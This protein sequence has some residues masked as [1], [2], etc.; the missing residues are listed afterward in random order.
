MKRLWMLVGVLAL[1]VRANAQ[2]VNPQG[3]FANAVNVNKPSLWLNFNDSTTAFKD[4]VSGASF[5]PT[6]TTGTILAPSGSLSA[7]Y[8]VV[9]GTVLPAMTVNQISVQF[10]TAP[11]AGPYTFVVV[12]GTAPSLTIASSF[13]L[14]VAATTA[15]Q[16]FTAPVNF[17]AFPVTAGE[18]F[19]YWASSST[20][21]VAYSA[22]GSGFYYAAAAS[23]LPLG[24]QTYGSSLTQNMSLA[25]G[26]SVPMGAGTAGQAGFDNTNNTNNSAG[27]AYN[28]FN[29]APSSAMSAIDWGSAWTMLLHVDR[30]NWDRTGT[31]VLASKGDMGSSLNSYWE[32][33]L[34]PSAT[35]ATASQ[36]CFLRNGYGQSQ[37]Q[38]TVCSGQYLDA[39]PNGFN[40][41]I[42][43]EDAGT[44]APSALSLY[45]NGTVLAT[46][47]GS[48]SYANGFGNVALGVSGGTGYASTTAFTSTGG[49]AN[50]I[51]TG[52]MY[53]TSGVPTSIT[54]PG[55][56][57]NQGCVSNATIVLTTPTGTGAVITATAK[58]MTMNSSTAPLMVPG[59]VSSGTTYGVGGT[60]AAQNPVYVDEFAL[61]PSAL[62]FGAIS[63]IFYETKF[64]QGLLYPGITA[65]PPL[66]ILGN[67]GCGPDYSG[68]Q[69]TAMVIG[70]HRAGLI[71]LIGVVD[72]D[73]AAN[74]LNSVA[75]YRQ[76]LDEAGLNDV[77]VSVGPN[78]T[79]TNTGGC[80]VANLTAYNASTPQNASA[81]G[82]SV[83][84]Y[85]TLFAKYPSTPIYVLMTQSANGYNAFQLSAADSLSPLTGLQLQAQNVAN[86]GW[87]NAFNGNN[88]ITPA[89][90]T[91]VLNNSGSMPVYF[92]G[93]TPAPGGPGIEAS[94]R[95]GDPLRLAA[96]ALNQDTIS[97]WT[98]LNLSQVLSPYFF[99][100]VLITF[101]GGTGYA[102]QTGY[103]STGG[104]TYCH[105]TG[106]MTASGGVPNGIETAWGAALPASAVY[107]GL[108][109]GCTSVPT[110]VLTAPTGSGV[111]LT[112]TTTILSA[113][114]GGAGV[115][116]YTVYPSQWGQ[117]SNSTTDNA[118][119]FTW[120]QNSLM[121]PPTNGAPRAF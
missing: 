103:T 55:T 91:S 29:V 63:N 70:A 80:P 26:G 86:G 16:T 104:G 56:S 12:S 5:G 99:G 69:T 18:R 64:Y 27:F 78:S 90:L 37:S 1:T 96:I 54:T 3:T 40:Y 21:T 47:G 98:N 44:G 118:P 112:A 48:N 62:S 22:S 43:I 25:V 93:S 11:T 42:V 35:F 19:G 83:T 59:Y 36:I 23:S 51:V 34:H 67:Q 89:A 30:L 111:A 28:Q 17:T 33:Y 105:V 94:R 71:R 77:P 108:G 4:S 121:D 9:Q 116:Q 45:V 46:S 58:A 14:T 100:G 107:N 61:F 119:V 95:V 85:R 41:D 76:M 68:D 50:C 117:V 106:I 60:D 15:V 115:N 81:Y 66:V 38:Q 82:S 13:T 84:M 65:N 31:L 73:A 52:T 110:I 24:A 8:V 53:A 101:S 10:Y 113:N 79:T 114:Y 72:D 6:G 32:V 39:M 97:G 74:G 102:N 92:W 2:A 7:G 88:S 75:W 49:G 109:Y 57:V 87:L 120:F 20:T